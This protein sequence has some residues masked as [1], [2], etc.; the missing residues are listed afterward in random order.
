MEKKVCRTDEAGVCRNPVTV[1]K[2]KNLYNDQ[3][4]ESIKNIMSY[5]ISLQVINKNAIYQKSM[6][7]LVQ[8][9]VYAFEASNKHNKLLGHISSTDGVLTFM[10]E[11][12]SLLP[13][14]VSMTR[15][16]GQ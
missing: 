16:S 9:H 4:Y 1:K 6:S 15:P 11:V 12:I 13:T 5:S 14:N 3:T 2:K 7:K 8:F 10:E